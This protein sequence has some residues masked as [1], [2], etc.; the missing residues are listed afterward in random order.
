MLK[1]I[2]KYVYKGQTV[3]LC[4]SNTSRKRSIVKSDSGGQRSGLQ[5]A[6]Q[7]LLSSVSRLK[8]LFDQCVLHTDLKRGNLQWSF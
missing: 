8:T 7:N 2:D 3:Q 5:E 1:V 4:R 6:T